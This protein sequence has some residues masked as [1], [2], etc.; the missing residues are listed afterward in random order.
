MKSAMTEKQTPGPAL[1]SE[2]SNDHSGGAA[3]RNALTLRK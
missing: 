3:A 2:T 1:V